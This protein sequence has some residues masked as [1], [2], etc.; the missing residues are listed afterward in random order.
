MPFVTLQSDEC[1]AAHSDDHPADRRPNNLIVYPGLCSANNARQTMLTRNVYLLLK[2]MERNALLNLLVELSPQRAI[3][4]ARSL[5]GPSILDYRFS[6][7]AYEG[8]VRLR[9][10]S[11]KLAILMH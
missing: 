5:D 9:T 8:G 2:F 6:D 1:S 3:N 10:K 7:S 11:L 4:K